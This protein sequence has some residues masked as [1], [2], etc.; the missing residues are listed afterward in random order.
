MNTIAFITPLSPP[1][2]SIGYKSPRLS[3]CDLILGLG[4]GD[5]K[6]VEVL[7]DMYCG[8][9]YGV[10]FRILKEEETAQ[11]VLQETFVRIWQSFS[12]YDA[13]KGRLYTWMSNL[14]RNLAIDKLKSKSFRNNSKNEKI[15]DLEQTVDLQFNIHNNPETIG[16]KEMVMKLKPE[17]KSIIDLVYYRGYTHMEAADELN[18]PV[19]TLKTRMRMA[20]S[21][22]RRCFK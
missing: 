7:Y 20:V 13:S 14:A 2:L 17:H 8:A 3:E 10:I 16:L 5:K 6:T 9:L 12:H 4:N 15:S 1:N 18:I 19:G 11:D 21:D 22:L